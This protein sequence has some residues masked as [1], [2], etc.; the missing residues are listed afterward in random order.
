M[1]A[2]SIKMYDKFGFVLWIE[3]NTN[4]VSQFQHYR[5]VQRYNTEQ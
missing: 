3:T 4:D 5:E 1:D 2:V